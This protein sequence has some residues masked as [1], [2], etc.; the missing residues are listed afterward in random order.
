M[1]Q[2]GICSADGG[3]WCH[4]NRVTGFTLPPALHHTATSTAVLPHNQVTLSATT[5]ETMILNSFDNGSDWFYSLS[6]NKIFSITFTAFEQNFERNKT[7]VME[8]LKR[9]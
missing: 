8:V 5:L 7:W 6:N 9:R 3:V 1:S 4:V 2:W